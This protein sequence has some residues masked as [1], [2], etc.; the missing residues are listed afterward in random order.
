M[1]RRLA[2]RAQDVDVAA[3]GAAWEKARS[4]G[5]VCVASG[6]DRV[7]RPGGEVEVFAG[8]MGLDVDGIIDRAE[9][10]EG[11]P[12]ACL[13][14]V[15][16]FERSLGRLKVREHIRLIEERLRDEEPGGD[17]PRE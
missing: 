4:L 14:D 10:V 2:G 8:W 16:A 12:F 7:V 1:V 11:L 9:L 5:P 15:L 6:G 3:R 17:G 13:E